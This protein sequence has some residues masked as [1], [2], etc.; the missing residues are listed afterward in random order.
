MSAISSWWPSKAARRKSRSP[1][2]GWTAWSAGRRM[3]PGCSSRA[4]GAADLSLWGQPI[5][6]GLP[7]QLA[8]LLKADI[9]CG[10][11]GGQCRRRSLCCSAGRWA[12]H[13]HRRGGLRNRAGHQAGH[14]RRRSVRR[15]ER[16]ARLVA[17]RKVPLL[18]LCAQLGWPKPLNRHRIARRWSGSRGTFE[19][20][21]W[22]SSILGPGQPIRFVT[23]G[24]DAEGRPGVSVSL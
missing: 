15:H 5:R 12:Q 16:V 7:Q 13:L 6:D 3:A 9:G 8:E 11:A 24:V 20:H 1:T 2:L 23:H 17:R 19:R 14:A 10:I 21:Q 4:I 18:R 22:P